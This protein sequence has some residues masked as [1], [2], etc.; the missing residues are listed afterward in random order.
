MY[1]YGCAVIN[2]KH[3]TDV[4]T[5][6][7]KSVW[8]LCSFALRLN[9]KVLV[10]CTGYKLLMLEL[11]EICCQGKNRIKWFILQSF[12]LRYLFSMH[13]LFL[14]STIGH[15]AYS[16]SWRARFYFP[17]C[18]KI[19]LSQSILLDSFIFLQRLCP[20]IMHYVWLALARYSN[21]MV[22]CHI[23]INM[24]MEPK[25]TKLHRNESWKLIDNLVTKAS[26][27]RDFFFNGL[28]TRNSCVI[29][30]RVPSI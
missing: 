13:H 2:P 9:S 8:Q 4:G 30:G 7:L 21:L 14:G 26:K 19:A 17:H 24:Q 27:N 10:N 23:H 11:I 20:A 29:Q 6:K 16:W 12:A 18:Q 15:V 5:R 22:L 25:N 1:S 28:M 3:T